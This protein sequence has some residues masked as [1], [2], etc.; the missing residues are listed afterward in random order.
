MQDS[1]SLCTCIAVMTRAILVIIIYRHTHNDSV[2]SGTF[3]IC[4][5]Y[6]VYIFYVLR[7]PQEL[8]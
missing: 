6:F 7:P 2:L 3:L 8:V 5:I 1:M 4:I